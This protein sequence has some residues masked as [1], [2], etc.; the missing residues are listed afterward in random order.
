MY[1]SVIVT[2]YKV[3]PYLRDCIDSILAQIFEDFELILVD[4]GSPDGCPAICD[5]Y[6]GE[7]GR[8]KVIHQKNQGVTAARKAGLRKAEGRYITFVD[9]DDRIRPEFLKR[10]YEKIEKTGAETVVFSCIHE[11]ERE[12]Y[13]RIVHEL[14]KEGLYRRTDIRKYIYPCL[15]MDMEM[16]HM[17]YYISGKIIISPLA[18]KCFLDVNEKISLGED[19]LGMVQVCRET[20]SVYL[21]HEPLHIYR[22]RTHSGAHGFR[23]EHYGQL[24]MV[25]EEL[26][27][28][29]KSAWD[30][31]EDFDRQILRYGAYMCF[32]FIVH[33]VNDRQLRRVKEIRREMR[34][35]SLEECLRKAQFKG[36]SPKTGITYGLLK[37][38]LY[39][40]SY[41]FLW[42]CGKIKNFAVKAVGNGHDGGREGTNQRYY[43]GL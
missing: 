19:M 20:E 28:L 34:R 9:G 30:L 27:R 32:T 6:A 31:P 36:I 41:L 23:M 13:S 16:R 15:L 12:K 35:P 43:T 5:V 42:L 2:V 4:D 10:G 24:C 3:E 7:D 8:V 14:V 18:K 40:A 39:L 25:L 21:S 1:F 38:E 26:K 29:E 11:H 37:K 17:T 33:A 22:V